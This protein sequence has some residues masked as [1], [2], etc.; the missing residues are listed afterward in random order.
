MTTA[1]LTIGDFSKMTYLSVKTLRHYHDVGVLEPVDI[2][3]S[4]GYR[5]YSPSQVGLAQMVRRLRD[6]G[7][8]LD[9]V[10]TIVQSPDPAARD[11]ALIAHLQRMEEQ[12]AQT[13]QTVA[14]L[15]SLLQEPGEQRSVVRR[16]IAATPALAISEVVEA[17]DAV[18][19]WMAAFGEL[20]QAVANTGVDRDGQDGALF[21]AEFFT[22]EAGEVTVFVPVAAVA[23]G[24]SLPS[25]VRLLVVPA[26]TAATTV[27]DGPFNDLDRAYG[28]LGKWVLEQAAG[29]DGPIREYYRPTGDA[30][31][32]LA[33]TTEVCWPVR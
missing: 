10:R 28:A 25:R 33:H 31:N 6:L 13:Q 2:D 12:L 5:F 3:P 27:H 29:A 9:E 7:M 20:H 18:A 17:A 1:N 4:S 14:S 21:P 23:E 30:G 24:L 8:P 32:L 22:D 26:V 16:E 11:A 19:W 15:R